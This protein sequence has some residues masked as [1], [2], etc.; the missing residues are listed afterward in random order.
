MAVGLIPL[1]FLHRLYFFQE[2][3]DVCITSSC[4]ISIFVLSN[5][6]RQSIVVFNAL[7]LQFLDLLFA[8]LDLLFL[9]MLLA[10]ALVCYLV[11]KLVQIVEISRMVLQRLALCENNNLIGDFVDKGAV[12]R[13]AQNSPLKMS[14]HILLQPLHSDDVEVVCGFI[15]KQYLWFHLQRRCKHSPHAPASTKLEDGTAHLLIIKTQTT[16]YFLHTPLRWAL[17]FLQLHNPIIDFIHALASI[18]IVQGAEFSHFLFQ[19][20]ELSVVTKHE[21]HHASRIIMNTCVLLN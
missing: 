16:Q 1:T 3:R 12:M 11:C 2:G 8:Q 17:A 5:I 14:Y 21:I 9:V 15:Q 4:V 20:F 10:V 6:C 13:H 18:K 7:L 19:S